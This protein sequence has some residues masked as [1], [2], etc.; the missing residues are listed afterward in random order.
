[1]IEVKNVNFMYGSSN[2]QELLDNNGLELPL[3]LIER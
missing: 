2:N 1:M 3:S